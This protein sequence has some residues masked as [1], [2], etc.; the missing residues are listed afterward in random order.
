MADRNDTD[1]RRYI[2]SDGYYKGDTRPAHQ[3]LHSVFQHLG[4]TAQHLCAALE[5]SPQLTSYMTGV[6]HDLDMQQE[7]KKAFGKP[8]TSVFLY[9]ATLG[10]PE[11]ADL[12]PGFL[13]L[14][15]AQ[16]S[17][18][19]GMKTNLNDIDTVDAFARLFLSRSFPG[20]F[21]PP[22]GDESKLLLC[23]PHMGPLFNT[24]ATSPLGNPGRAT[25]LQAGMMYE[26][27]DILQE[28]IKIMQLPTDQQER[29]FQ[30]FFDR[31][32][33]PIKEAMSPDDY[34]QIMQDTFANLKKEASP[35]TKPDAKPDTGPPS[36]APAQRTRPAPTP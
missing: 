32:L 16:E 29:E 18:I 11:N 30:A 2:G 19:T 1:T 9:M 21:P 17:F 31:K 23:S 6:L 34:Q 4:G 28:T 10:R 15:K 12:R 20:S 14:I 8:E 33:A 7:L 35:D 5:Q 3:L 27:L 36:T 22:T 24:L 13:S 25:M 26:S